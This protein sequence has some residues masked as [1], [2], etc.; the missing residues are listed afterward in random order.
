MKDAKIRLYVEHPLGEGQTL[1]LSRDQA[2]YLFGVMRLGT[3]DAV[4]VFNG[5][6]GEWRATVQEAGKRGGT[7][8]CEAARLPRSKPAGE[9]AG[10]AQPTRRLSP[11]ATNHARSGMAG[12]PGFW[13]RN[14][15]PA[16]VER[17]GPR[18][19]TAETQQHVRC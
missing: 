18:S 12:G 5:Q 13:N 2:H 1:P 4:L 8:R 11:S 19:G 16:G 6:A 7:L 9:R 3:G 15:F 17:G 10:V 14:L